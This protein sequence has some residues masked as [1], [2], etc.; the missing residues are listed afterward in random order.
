MSILCQ[1]LKALKVALKFWNK[2]SFGDVHKRVDNASV[3][4]ESVQ[5]EILNNCVYDVLSAKEQLAQ[6]EFQ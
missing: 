1:K 5:Q 4:L 6:T 3:E 2:T